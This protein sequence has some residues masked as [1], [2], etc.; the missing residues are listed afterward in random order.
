MALRR[1]LQG[2]AAIKTGS[3]QAK[4]GPRL[5]D[6]DRTVREAIWWRFG[7]DEWAAFDA[8]PPAIRQRIQCH[9]YDA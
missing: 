9:A 1:Q 6:N 2:A 3:V 8:L 4:V 5:P 7:G